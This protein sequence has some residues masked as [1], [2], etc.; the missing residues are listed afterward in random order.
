MFS[1]PMFKARITLGYSEL[2]S[3]DPI[4]LC[5][6]FLGYATYAPAAGSEPGSRL[7]LSGTTMPRL[8]ASLIIPCSVTATA[9]IVVCISTVFWCASSF[10]KSINLSFASSLPNS[11]VSC[12]LYS[13]NFSKSSLYS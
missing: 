11:A 4:Q 13:I 8:C 2:I 9:P 6:P 7:T 12:L 10:D 3:I 1:L 5:S